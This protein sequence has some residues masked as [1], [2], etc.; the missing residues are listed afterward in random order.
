MNLVN[1]FVG[2][3]LLTLGRKLFWLFVG[4]VGFAT[5]YSYA[6]QI[7]GSEAGLT[8]LV[9]ALVTGLVGA[10]LAVLL[11]RLS[12]GLAGFLAGGYL[13]IRIPSRFGLE[14]EQLYWALYLLGG[15]L[16]AVFSY[17]IFDWALILL[18]SLSG[19]FLVVEAAGFSPQV[20][21]LLF[22]ALTI[23]GVFFQAGLMRRE[24]FSGRAPAP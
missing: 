4:C 8:I 21:I 14:L 7:W 17:L 3:F 22:V 24:R 2:L 11:Q 16:G 12:I 1:L 15:L 23:A 10:L 9:F 6:Q 19:A 13:A 5:G 20:E 18:S